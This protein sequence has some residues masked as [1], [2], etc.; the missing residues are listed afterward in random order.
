[1]GD[2]SASDSSFDLFS[3][4]T[5]CCAPV[6]IAEDVRIYLV[7]YIFCIIDCQDIFDRIDIMYYRLPYVSGDTLSLKTLAL[8]ILVDTP[9]ILV[10]TPHDTAGY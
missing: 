1:V 7:G 5:V 9:H 2:V 8:Y 4:L 6:V 3:S 10:D